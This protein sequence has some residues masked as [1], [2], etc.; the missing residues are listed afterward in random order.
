MFRL[1]ERGTTVKREVMAGCTTFMTMSYIIFVQPMLLS[2]AG[3]DAGA[4]MVATC[5]ASAG[6]MLLM[7]LLTNYP[8]ALAPGMGINAYF[9]FT[10]CIGANMP[11][12]DALGITFVAGVLFIL[13]AV[14]GLQEAVMYAIPPSLQHAIAVGIGLFVTFIG[15]Q[16]GGLVVAHPATLVTLG[17]VTSPPVLLT[18][19]G[20]VVTLALTARGIGGAILIGIV[21]NFI[22]ALCFGMLEFDGVVSAPPSLAPTLL[23][24]NLSNVFSS[25]EIISIAFVILL[26]D[27]F[28]SIGSL[29]AVGHQADLMHNNK[30]PKGK[31]A[32]LVDAIAS[33]GGAVLGTSTVVSYIESV[34]GV[35][36]GGR[37]G[38]TTLTVAVLM[39]LSLVFYP[40]VQVVGAGYAVSDTITL[41]PLIAP[42]LIV[43]G[44]FMVKSLVT[45][46]WDDFTEATPAFLTM[47]VI[48]LSFSVTDGITIGFIS[49]ALLKLVTGRGKELHWLIYLFALF[50]IVRQIVSA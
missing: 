49:C 38:L 17:D 23:Q 12:Q 13:M 43:V 36:A 28:G 48:P 20:V 21:L 16:M 46:Y 35:A 4:V 42:A 31:Q 6:A 40:L 19:F 14:T 47:L 37:T 15:L 29:T 24:L 34:A 30:L 45:I 1:Q 2:A 32:L 33:T 27:M 25:V 50:F 9:V 39:L 8:V 10:L 3:M 11:W 22:V 41:Y 7:A 26:M 18:I 44:S 5:L